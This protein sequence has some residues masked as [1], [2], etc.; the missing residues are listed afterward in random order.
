MSEVDAGSR[1][2]VASLLWATAYVGLG[3]A[4]IAL[5]ADREGVEA[6]LIGGAMVWA[7]AYL[8]DRFA[9]ARV[10]SKPRRT[11]AIVSAVYLI[12]CLVESS[13]ALEALRE[14]QEDQAL[15]FGLA[16][17]FAVAALASARNREPSDGVLLTQLSFH[18]LMLIPALAILINAG[19]V[20]VAVPG[21]IGL[22]APL[23][24]TLIVVASVPMPLVFV[25]D[26]AVLATDFHRPAED[27]D[28]PATTLLVVQAACL[29][30][31]L[32]WAHN[33]V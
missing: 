5:P 19:L 21:T 18:G 30:E 26:L 7:I 20:L 32:R 15:W 17:G 33:G 24:R 9:K 22:A 13:A 28:R 12:A 1:W 31:V 23:T 4:T 3:L 25:T 10:A 14:R 27:R 2:T 11:T 29:V 8:L 16:L 6:L